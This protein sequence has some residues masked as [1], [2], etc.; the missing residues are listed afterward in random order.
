M[1]DKNRI[2]LGLMTFGPNVQWGAKVTSLDEFGQFLDLFQTA[3]YNEVDTSR[4]YQNGE[5]EAFTA[6]VRWKERNLT[7]ATKIYPFR[8]GMHDPQNLRAGLEKSLQELQTESVDIFY[9]HAADRSVPFKRT[10]HCIDELYRQ[11]KFRQFGLSNYT[12]FEVAEIVMICREKGWIRPS[13]Y[14]AMYSPITRSIE[15]ELIPACRRYGIDIVTYNGLAGG[16]FT[17]KYK[18]GKTEA[19]ANMTQIDRT[20]RA[21]FLSDASLEA[22][23]V[24]EPVVLAHGLTL[25]DAAMRWLVYHSALRMR[26]SGG[27][28]GLVI[29]ASSISQLKNNLEVIERGPLPKEVVDVL[30]RGWRIAKGQ[31]PEYWHLDLN[32]TYDT[33]EELF[34]GSCD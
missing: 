21:R 18:Q 23:S 34:G 25:I 32:Y 33:C 26:Y 31:A 5:Q 20:Y 16:L 30:D 15:A 19:P 28:D 8:P 2:I 3:G 9:L 11:G 17:G 1:A 24:I 6:A 7:L 10:L 12:S 13:I 27:N 4:L 22:L 14:Q 29:G